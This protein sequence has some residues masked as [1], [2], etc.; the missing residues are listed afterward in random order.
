MCGI[1]SFIAHEFGHAVGLA[2]LT[3]D[4]NKRLLL[5][6]SMRNDTLQYGVTSYDRKAASYCDI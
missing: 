1:Y 6:K 5:Y 4:E 2:H 3:W